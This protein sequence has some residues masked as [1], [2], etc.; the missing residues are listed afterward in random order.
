MIDV[1]YYIIIEREIR[2]SDFRDHFLIDESLT[3]AVLL[4]LIYKCKKKKKTVDSG[5][6]EKRRV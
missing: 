6:T 1:A 4:V 3:D 2:K 5:E